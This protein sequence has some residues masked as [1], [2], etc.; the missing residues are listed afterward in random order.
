MPEGRIRNVPKFS[1]QFCTQTEVR[2]EKNFNFTRIKAWMEFVNIETC[3][4]GGKY[5]IGVFNL[6][7]QR[8]YVWSRPSLMHQ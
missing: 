6:T 2:Y 5:Y 1:K 8:K 4:Q 3:F 7:V